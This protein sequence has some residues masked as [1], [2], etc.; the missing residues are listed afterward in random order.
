MQILRIL[1]AQAA[2]L[3]LSPMLSSAQK[4]ELSPT[5][6][7]ELPSHRLAWETENGIRYRLEKSDNLRAWSLVPGFP[8]ASDSPADQFL[9]NPGKSQEFFR[10]VPLDEQPPKIVRIFPE[11]DAFGVSRTSRIEIDIED[12]TGVVPDSISLRIGSSSPLTLSDPRMAISGGKLTFN[13]GSTP[14]GAPGEI[15]GISVTAADPAGRTVT[16][17]WSCELEV[18]PVLA[19]GIFILGSPTAIAAGQV[20]PDGGTPANP[21]RTWT[22]TDVAEDALQISYKGAPPT[23]F[24]VGLKVCNSVPVTESDSFFRRIVSIETDTAAGI[25]T[26]LTS[27]ARLGE[28]IREGSFSF[29]V[30]PE[31]TTGIRRAGKKFEFKQALPTIGGSFGD[32]VIVDGSDIEVK[33]TQSKLEISSGLTASIDFYN[34]DVRRFKASFSGTVEG[35]IGTRLS[36]SA[37]ATLT[38]RKNLFTFSRPIFIPVGWFPIPLILRGTVQAFGGASSS[39]EGWVGSSVSQSTGFTFRCDYDSR[40]LN[41]LD[42]DADI[43]PGPVER[44]PLTFELE[45]EARA[46]GGFEGSLETSI[47]GAVGFRAKVIPRFGFRGESATDPQVGRRAKWT[48]YALG[49]FEASLFLIG[50]QSW[51]LFEQPL[52]RSEWVL[53]FPK[54]D[55]NLLLS[56]AR[57]VSRSGKS[58]TLTVKGCTPDSARFRWFHNGKLIPGLTGDTYHIGRVDESHDGIYRVDTEVNGARKQSNPAEIAVGYQIDYETVSVATQPEVKKLIP[59]PDGDG[60]MEVTL[61]AASSEPQDQVGAQFRYIAM[62]E[63]DGDTDTVTV[64]VRVENE[65]GLQGGDGEI[66]T[67]SGNYDGETGGF[68]INVTLPKEKLFTDSMGI[69]YF[70]QSTQVCRGQY[71]PA[72]DTFSGTLTEVWTQ[73]WDL[74]SRT[75]KATTVGRFRGK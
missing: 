56:P 30:T 27:D 46:E 60:L 62:C 39:V 68:L 10:V 72:T 64:S 63:F 74:D 59:N 43:D 8:R 34:G 50:G 36:A 26:L 7:L 65:D 29:S 18:P 57:N 38:G 37:Q 13:P 75:V 3:L 73:S 11:P 32:T 45:G 49:D 47:L 21:A 19:P 51:T 67:F 15:V 66:L 55:E 53:C 24:T 23:V 20:P 14:L 17:A 28:F 25:L 58:V 52:Y 16:K 40:R 70:G 41:K 42:F 4:L 12:M 71:Y 44:K 5:G 61:S 35:L 6:P 31:Q 54:T 48:L 9:F 2:A 22:L 69:T 33:L 1:T